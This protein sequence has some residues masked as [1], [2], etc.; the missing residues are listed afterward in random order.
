MDVHD[1][2]GATI[3]TGYRLSAP[4]EIPIPAPGRIIVFY[5]DGKGDLDLGRQYIKRADGSVTPA[6]RLP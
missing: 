6:T 1:H 4:W 3:G 2:N 5:S